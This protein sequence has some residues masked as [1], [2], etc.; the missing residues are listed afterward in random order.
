MFDANLR[1]LP[2]GLTIIV[3]AESVKKESAL[4]QAGARKGQL[5]K[6]T[7]PQSKVDPDLVDGFNNTINVEINGE[8]VETSDGI[9]LSIERLEFFKVMP[10]APEYYTEHNHPLHSFWSK[11]NAL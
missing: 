2:P 1:Y 10:T 11:L 8:W 5:F 4:F 3:M 6:A 9:P 7:V